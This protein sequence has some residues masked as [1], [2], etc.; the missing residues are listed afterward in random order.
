MPWLVLLSLSVFLYSLTTLFQR[1][2]LKEKS[3]DPVTHSILFQLLTGILLVIYGYLFTDMSVP[4]L[5]PFLLSLGIMTVLYGFGNILYC[6]ALKTI[7]A[8]TFTVIFSSRVFFTII[9]S[10]LLL[11]E[12]LTLR[13]FIGMLFIFGSV[14]LVSIRSS[15]FH[16]SRNVFIALF[17]AI[18]FGVANTNDRFLLQSFSVYPYVASAFLFPA[19]FMM[20]LKPFALKGIS[21]YVTKNIFWKLITL[22]LIY[23]ASSITF[24]MALQKSTNSSQL[25]SINLTSVIVTVILAIIFLHEKDNIITKIVAAILSLL[26]VLLLV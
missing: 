23:A 6:Y 16:F 2:L 20:I 26:G 9:A 12:G 1:I 17:A 4:N 3:I 8:S 15:H 7:E 11:G 14:I 13:Q 10:S 24:F 22:C 19:I 5:K 25:V 18:M 21:Q